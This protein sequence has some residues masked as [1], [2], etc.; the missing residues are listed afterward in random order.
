MLEESGHLAAGLAATLRERLLE[1]ATQLVMD[2]RSLG[3]ALAGVEAREVI[4][5]LAQLAGVV[6]ATLL[7]QRLAARIM[8]RS[9]ERA[10]QR[11]PAMRGRLMPLRG[12][13]LVLL[14]LLGGGVALGVAVGIGYLATLLLFLEVTAGVAAANAFLMAFAVTGLGR[15]TLG[16]FLAPDSP[17]AR[18]LPLD[19]DQA[20]GWYQRL[21]RLIVTAAY[22]LLLAAPLAGS[23]L[24]GLAS[25]VSVVV[26]G[27]VL[28]QS[29]RVLRDLRTPVANWLSKLGHARH[30]GVFQPMLRLLAPIWHWLAAGYAIVVAVLGILG[31][32]GA[33]GFLA[34]ASLLSA[35]TLLTAGF[36]G[37]W[38]GLLLRD[39]TPLPARLMAR[40]PSLQRRMAVW[41]PRLL[42]LIH[43]LLAAG[44]IACLLQIWQL[45]DV[46]SWL[47]GPVGSAVLGAVAG[48][49][50]IL[51]VALVAWLG[52]VTWIEDRLNPDTGHGEPGA[53]EKTLLALFRNAIAIAIVTI[54]GM[55]V[56]S[57]IGIDIGPLIAGAGVIGLAIGFGAQKLVQDIITGVF[58]QL[59]DAIH[60]DDYITAAGIS[61][62]VERLSIRS[63]GLRDL[64]GTLHVV[65]FSSVDTVSNYTRDFGYHLG[66]YGVAYRENIG[67][68]IEHLHKAYERLC[69]DSVIGPE[70]TGP[71]EVDGVTALADSSVNVRVRI[72][73]TAGMQWAVGRAYNRAVKEVFDEAGIEIPFPHMTLYFGEARDGTA[74]PAHLAIRKEGN[75]EG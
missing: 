70:V 75:E 42:G 11:L 14:R 72:L 18:L 47:A 62:T 56:L 53:R 38:L 6:L 36:A 24:P 45:A 23:F 33:L 28:A 10:A 54:A 9:V 20:R 49:L 63:L 61:G 66:E 40:F 31:P 73:T 32:P 16:A 8:Q 58:I 5:L 22:G 57:E 27:L 65:P 35:L 2:A 41:L 64:T 21:G 12:L 29:L 44:V 67:D 4:V 7:A 52:A 51:L 46:R 74:P 30:A 71:L 26:V 59:E 68:V 37:Y 25:L 1:W 55:V 43:M 19:S 3:P 69:A 17:A 39:R 34:M 15:L 48:V 50:G 13:I 60:Q